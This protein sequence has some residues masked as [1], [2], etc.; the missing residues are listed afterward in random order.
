M[1]QPA[2]FYYTSYELSNP[3]VNY[4]LVLF[5]QFL[6]RTLVFADADAAEDTT[7]IKE[8]D[9]SAAKKH[10]L[11]QIGYSRVVYVLQTCSRHLFRSISDESDEKLP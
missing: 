5:S 3:Y 10:R 11:C 1:V 4:R 7:A 6:W 9:K 8:F 2:G